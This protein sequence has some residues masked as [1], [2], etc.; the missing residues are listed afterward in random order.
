MA[1]YSH[2]DYIKSAEQ[3]RYIVN[4]V[5]LPSQLP[6]KDDYN[7]GH[8][9]A[10]LWAVIEA[11]H[12][13]KDHT[14]DY[15][16][17][18]IDSIINSLQPLRLSTS[19]EKQLL[20]AFD[21]FLIRNHGTVVFHVKEQ[22]AGIMFTRSDASVHAEVFELSANNRSVMS[23]EGRLLRVFPGSSSAIPLETFHLPEF[24]ES[25]AHTLDKMS[26]QRTYD[27]KP[28]ARKKGKMHD[29]DRDTTH[30]KMVTDFFSALLSYLGSPVEVDSIIKHTREEIFWKDCKAPWHRS[31]LWLLIRV[32]LQLQFSRSA[33]SYKCPGQAYKTFMLFFMTK[34]L[35]RAHVCNLSSELLSAMNSKLSRRCQKVAGFAPENIV[36]SVKS[37]LSAT[38]QIL[39]ERWSE[40]QRQSH[41][42]HNMEHLRDM[43]LENDAHIYLL[44]LDNYIRSI[45]HRGQGSGASLL[46]LSTPL[47]SYT[48]SNIP[49]FTAPLDDSDIAYTLAAIEFWVADSLP[50]WIRENERGSMTC[51]SLMSLIVD[52]FKAALIH[53][54]GNP[55]MTSVMILTILELWVA[56]DKSAVQNCALLEKYKPGVPLE[57]LENLNLPLSEQMER[58]QEIE[59]YL[60][61]R[62]SRAPYTC[63]DVF[64]SYGSARSFSVLYFDQSMQ[65]RNLLATIEKDARRAREKKRQEFRNARR[66]FDDLMQ[67]SRA[68]DHKYTTT[69]DPVTGEYSDHHY[70]WDCLKCGLE[71]QAYSMQISIHEWPL[72]E[73]K[74]EAK[75]TVFELQV[76]P[77]FGYWRDTTMFILF[78][79]LGSRYHA[80]KTTDSKNSLSNPLTN[81]YF[82]P[83]DQY[84]RITLRS[85]AKS[86]TRTH[87]SVRDL[88]I[89]KESEICL[90][91]GLH[92]KYFDTTE[93]CFVTHLGT[94]QT[95]PELCTYSI[96]DKSTDQISPIQ[97]FINRPASEPHGPPPNTVLASQSTCP[98]DLSLEEY[99]ALT[100]LPLGS[101]IQWQNILVQL[102][103]PSIDFKREETMLVILQCIF[104]AGPRDGGNILRTGHKV[105]SDNSFAH[106]LLGRL[107]EALGRVQENWQSFQALGI[108][109]ALSRRLL[110][111]APMEDVKHECLRFLATTREVALDWIR[112]L[113]EKIQS[114]TDDDIRKDLRYKTTRIALIC[115]DTF[116]VDDEQLRRLLASPHDA[117]I[118]IRCAI[119]LQEG[120]C[121]VTRTA[122]GIEF[123]MRQRWDQL[124]YRGFSI[125]SN[126]IVNNNNPALE[127]AIKESWPVF[128]PINAWRIR[129]RPYHHWLEIRSAREEGSGSL[130]VHFSTLTGELL[131]DGSPLSRL[132]KEYEQHS[133]YST[134]FGRTVIEVR[135]SSI[136]GMRYSSKKAFSGH[137]V[138]FGMNYQDKNIHIRAATNG[139]VF[140]LIPRYIL[141][142][143]FP[144]MFVNNF[145][146]WYNKSEGYLEFCAQ[147]LPW[148][149]SEKNWRLF[150]SGYT[151][152]LA[153]GN[154]FLVSIRSATAMR[155]SSILGCLEP[156]P[157]IHIILREYSLDIELPRLKLGFYTKKGGTSISSRQFRGMVVDEDQSIGTL[158]G[159]ETKLVLRGQDGG[160]RRKVIIPSGVIRFFRSPHIPETLQH[161]VVQIEHCSNTRAHSYEIDNLLGRLI[162]NSS[163][164]SRLLISYLHALTSF[165]LPD[166]LTGKTG[167]ESALTI[168]NSAAVRSFKCLTEEDIDLLQHMAALTP[169]RVYYP[170]DEQDM[171]TVHWS[172]DLGFLAQHGNF[173]ESVDSIYKQAR[174]SEFL[175]P[176]SH[177]ALPD[178]QD[179]NYTLL[180]RDLIRSSVFRIV[181]FGAEAHTDKY[182][183]KYQARDREKYSSQA[184]QAV[185]LSSMLFE[186]DFTLRYDIKGNV[187]SV[188]WDFIKNHVKG[189]TRGPSFSLSAS[190]LQYDSGLLLNPYPF[191]AEQWIPLHRLLSN[192]GARPN[193]FQMM[194]WLAAIAYIKDAELSILQILASFYAAPDMALIA[195]PNVATFDLSNGFDIRT[196][197]LS[198]LF[199]DC[200]LKFHQVP[201]SNLPRNYG[202][203]NSNYNNRRRRQHNI[204][205]SEAISTLTS[206]LKAQWPC[207]VP[208]YPD[209]T[210]Y[211]KLCT[212][213]NMTSAMERARG[214]FKPC[215]DNHLLVLYF[216]KIGRS[217]TRETSTVEV[218]RGIPFA[219][220]P[221]PTKFR[222]VKNDDVLSSSA[223]VILPYMAKDSQYLSYN[224]NNQTPRLPSLLSRLEEQAQSGYERRYVED[225]GSSVESLQSWRMEYRLPLEA[226]ELEPL[227]I[228][229]QS[230][231][232]S[233]VD[234]IYITMRE[235]VEE[236][237]RTREASSQHWPRISPI[238][239]LERLSYHYW[240]TL[241]EGWRI[242]I[243]HYGVAISHLQRAQRLLRAINNPSA[244]IKELRN[245][246]HI[247]WK[248]IDQPDSLLL[249]IESDLMIREVQ[250]DIAKHMRSPE[251]GKNSV[252]QLNMGEGK[253]SVIV[254]A[255]A[256]ALADGERLV[257][258]IVGKPQSKQ[259]FQMLVSKLGG[260][261]NRRIYHMPFS[262]A[263][264]V[265]RAEIEAMTKM[266]NSCIENGGVFLVQP[267]HILSF[268][269]MGIECILTGREEIGLPLTQLQASLDD[270]TRDIVDESDENFSVKF[271]LVYTMGTQ[272]PTEF[273]PDRWICIQQL[274]DIVRSVISKAHSELP[275][276]IELRFQ[277][278]GCFPWTRIIKPDAADQIL[279]RITERVCAT[280][281]NGFPITRQPELIRGAVYRYITEV[282]P[283]ADDIA[284]VEDESPNGF[285]TGAKD[286]LLLLR[287]LIAGG[288]L[289]FAFGHKRWRVDYGLDG[290]RN[291]ST[292]LAV[293]YR[294]KDSPS[295]RSEFSHP[296]VVILLTSLSY[297]YGGLSDED[298]FLTFNH[299]FK[300]D[301]AELEYGMWARAANDLAPA[302]RQLVGINLEDSQCTEHV[303]KNLR[304][305][306][307]VIDYFLAH[308]V[309]AKE[310]KEFPHKLSASGWDIGEV[311]DHPTT[312]FSG[313][314]DSRKV[315][316]LHVE[317]LDLP[318]QKHTNAL[319][320][321]Y[322]LQPEN[323]VELM[324]P[325]REMDVSVAEMLLDIITRMEPPTRVIL[326]VGAQILEL[327]NLGVAKAWLRRNSHDGQ[328]QAAVYFDDHDEL[329]VI[330][331]RGHSEPLQ[332]SPYATQLDT[333]LVFLDEAHTRGTDL[334][335]PKN[336]RAAVT[337]GANLTKDRLV[338][339]CM[340]MRMLGEGQSVVFCVPEEIRAKIQAR[341]SDPDPFAR[342]EISVLDILA[343]TIGETWQDIHRSMGLWANQGRRHEVHLK[344][345]EAA[346]A[347]KSIDRGFIFE[348]SLAE[349]Y[350]EDESQTLERRYRPRKKGTN[351]LGIL[352]NENTMDPISKRCREFTN[353]NLDSAALQE[354][355]ERE[356]SPEIEQEREDQRP[357]AAKPD[358]HSIHPHVESFVTSGTIYSTSQGYGPAFMAL[359]RTTAGALLKVHSFQP[360]LLATI[361]FERTIRNHRKGIDV[362]DFYQR[363]VQWIL[364]SGRPNDKF[365]KHMMVISPYEAQMLLP[366]IQASNAVALHLYAPRSSLGY[367]P[368][369]KLDLYTVPERLSQ[370][371]IPQRLIT[372]LNLF[373]G[374]LYFD[375]FEQYVDACK[376]MGISYD[377]PGEGEEIA[378][379]GFILRDAFGIV[380]G[381]SGLQRSPV[382]FFKVLHTKIRRN[383]ESI[384]KTHMGKLLDNQL[385][386]PED[387]ENDG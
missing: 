304:Y 142:G 146:H 18:L 309:F 107:H 102:A 67:R 344:V 83:F 179:V 154:S 257:R 167:T 369:D 47:E 356:L 59:T 330:D 218:E 61:R 266:V 248:P 358:I 36:E 279:R 318:A 234:E 88:S 53:Y 280:G 365:V 92:Y 86:H 213:I 43:N 45:D 361:D 249:E 269:L 235:S 3:V 169:K 217:I 184:S 222:L 241:P 27:T 337:L 84:Q 35:M 48:S 306:K 138:D 23:T 328:I 111:L 313:T 28:K 64:L 63:Y 355:E 375:S 283:R 120:L 210:T 215:F 230:A 80:A 307:G 1:A 360:G 327:D 247:N 262:R 326:D 281:L 366:K 324:P 91:N 316:P 378:A 223:P 57:L 180:R 261:L 194:F 173:F 144:A 254:P 221:S 8:E 21:A 98:G 134:L 323:S 137:R 112:V 87:R 182:D 353:L 350:L 379:D 118:M 62:E 51:R 233:V 368:L 71:Q 170:P 24:Q 277:A 104:Q 143:S 315:L 94:T 152:R 250:E 336:Y 129:K 236:S 122:E 41:V 287:G 82:R 211:A 204:K 135:P 346:R 19:N 178:L 52:Y 357:P 349:K 240:E 188:I 103:M 297:Y 124:S 123:I 177:V 171:Q 265:E 78:N 367:R 121:H 264:K 40:I 34:I 237:L 151:W 114:T 186:E 75:S 157:W 354:E 174:E 37:S 255:V 383:C 333:C 321:E 232:Q 190:E 156:L 68:A 166:Q 342:E 310:M 295:P 380:G 16:S 127:N 13:F 139:Q 224:E 22:N 332:A 81:D 12:D 381:E 85:G 73:D 374:Q 371:Q 292:K 97:Q 79:V 286:T 302:F 29:E 165:P 30:P 325:R 95:V 117:C 382:K 298:L 343:W 56:S 377:T 11:L 284:L 300:S 90:E 335:L 231:C 44:E 256:A 272:R 364:T 176:E 289:A 130:E 384:S 274:L 214:R 69:E 140:E 208:A 263:V 322:L 39:Q 150:R 126:Q 275:G 239:F 252:M 238:F 228:S 273:S 76:P 362:L 387:F 339:A 370:R 291:P 119:V 131:I 77:F 258:V 305:V 348:K 105:L 245:P 373:A 386:R 363:S 33:T 58:L 25:I 132:P 49:S 191:I 243:V 162:N 148:D 109:V 46:R 192:P 158:T 351:S 331:R 225:L 9:E 163:L 209:G 308:I 259:M 352:S 293:P 116:N 14:Q 199:E 147:E 216:E 288:V 2:N 4:H 50:K 7:A 220:L 312:G 125:F 200:C 187:G 115:A 385:L 38:N 128:R 6:Q 65:H 282:E 110:S 314:N 260:L 334:K 164:Q 345:W 212:Y 271:E 89:Q 113:D 93:D 303:F 20:E 301:Q 347:N 72:P 359:Q 341:K 227:I 193:K 311:K 299:L 99:K 133:M 159:L 153:K 10:L 195:G 32:A 189:P 285:W 106:A 100:S 168:L 242:W 294:A 226:E 201:E 74:L 219:S 207:G 31:A 17:D 96:S 244:L 172:S 60:L 160:L 267:E 197:N 70:K 296:D 198:G 253:S 376:F 196:T 320:L 175:Y 42:S 203:N 329:C 155:I 181:G 202:E 276:S 183:V 141:H 5:F 229:H 161:V 145:V 108:F 268:K 338:Q 251:S 26:H 136:P 185:A 270:W 278:F 66:Q 54:Q 290:N 101:S 340:R 205:K 317:Q 246:G 206:A 15:E 55:E 372:Q 149:H 319:V